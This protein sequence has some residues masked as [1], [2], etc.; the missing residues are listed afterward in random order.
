MA[1]D[2]LRSFPYCECDDLGCE[3]EHA[4]L[5]GGAKALFDSKVA[6]Q[7]LATT[8][9]PKVIANIEFMGISTVLWQATHEAWVLGLEA[10]K[11]IGREEATHARP[12]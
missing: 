4:P 6:I 5:S 3:R 2:P 1:L 11:V 9:A 8:Y 10:G 12:T 7:K